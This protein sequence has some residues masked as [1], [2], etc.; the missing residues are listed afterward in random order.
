MFDLFRS[1]AKAVRYFLGGLL[2]LIALS[3][4][5]TLIPGFGSST[6]SGDDQVVAEIGK[7][8]LTVREVQSDVQQLVRSRQ[9]PSEMIPIYLPQRID[10]MITDRAV[11]YEAERRGYEVPDTELAAVIRSI[12]PRFFQ[13]GKL[14]DKTAYEN[15]LNEQGF[16]IPDFEANLRKQIQMKRLMDLALEG[17]VVT[18]DEVKRE[19]ER[20]NEKVKVAYIGFKPDNLKS[21]VKVT[22]EELQAYYNNNKA[23]YT[24]PEKRDIAVLVADQDKIAASISV[25][26]EQL[27]R[28][29]DGNKD[30]FRTPER[31]K[32]RHILLMTTGKSPDEVNK[33]KAKAEDIRKKLTNANFGELAKANS[34]DPG[35]KDKGG[36]LGWVVRGQMVKNFENASFN[37]KAGDIGPL[38]QTEYGYHIVQV[39]EKE[40]A[41]LRPFDEVKAQLATDAKKAQ[42]GERTQNAIE[43]A[44][45]AL[46]RTPGNLE[47]I[48]K[49]YDLELI[50]AEKVPPGG[51]IGNL[52]TNTELD[53]ALASLKA[54]EVSPVFQLSQT[55]LG[56]AEVIDVVP[57]RLATFAESE[58]RIRD[59]FAVQ[60][61][62]ALSMERAQQ[63]A[64]R[65][66][67]GE[68]LQKVAKDLGGEYK[69]PAEFTSDAAIEGL[70]SATSL[71]EAF[72][73]PV[74]S[75]L[76]PL[77]IVGQQVIAK[78]T[79]KVA[80]DAALLTTQREQ[81]VL[82]LKQKKGNE[83]KD[84]FQDSILAK[85]L[86][87][88]KVKKHN[89]TIK[90]VIA[91]YRS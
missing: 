90:R 11:A 83:R 68:D 91:A 8:R 3:M 45:T 25:T 85:L 53:T 49:Q 35:S 36:E 17:I 80:A 14:I 87:E 29:Y 55:K 47:Q 82:T 73:K 58:S 41:R 13:D 43:Q 21:L 28:A 59:N 77:N 54:H 65:V 15:F 66:K 71:A 34:E 2:G 88:G 1:R 50:K 4:V 26:D 16:T 23:S 44:H 7:N 78:V 38:V 18:P 42:I 69:T 62:Q 20:R 31:S 40:V 61:A 30:A 70:G 24:E 81:I 79:D 37:Q 89:D 75:V 51:V 86:K 52:G 67:A 48:A 5:I 74:G 12:L 64:Q 72:S 39:E 57:T 56:V 10:Q 63:A 46:Q 27:H 33:I 9:I 6:S 60:K 84:L 32:V 76:G 22:P 19:F